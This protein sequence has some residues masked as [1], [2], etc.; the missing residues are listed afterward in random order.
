[1][2]KYTR[3]YENGYNGIA[4]EQFNTLVIDHCL[5]ERSGTN[6]IHI[7]ASTAEVT[8]SMVLHNNG[9]GLSVDD[10]GEL[11]IHGVVVEDN[12]GGVTLGDGENT[13]MLGNALISHNRDCDI[14]GEVHQVEDKAPI[15]EMIDFAFEPDMDYALGYIP[16]DIEEDKYLY[17]YPDEDETRRVVKEIGNELGL[18]WAI[19]WDGEAVWTATLWSAFYK[20]DPNTGEVLQHFKGPGSQPWG[21]A[22][23]GENLWVVDFAEKTI[24]EVNPENGRVLSSFQ[25][26][27]PVGGC[28]GLTWDGEYLYVLGWATHV[29]YQMDREGNLIQTILLEADGGGGLA[30]DGKFFW[31]PGGPGIIKVDREGRQVGWIYAASEGTW[32]L[33]WGNDLL[34]ATQRTNE[35]WFDDKVFGIE[36]IN[37][38]SQ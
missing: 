12:G 13:V 24:F 18:T 38:H 20:L 15:P 10:N 30:W 19:A 2:I 29:I 11:K 16:G 33:A 21:M 3:I 35:N 26:P 37:D 14:C 1:L 9:G 17:I 7:D 5:V 32:D 23:D 36:I 28:K 4:A 34:W 27:D 8:S 6:G 25:S 22:F 31:M